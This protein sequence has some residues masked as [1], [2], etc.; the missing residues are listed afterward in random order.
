M[1]MSLNKLQELVME[2]KPGMLQSMG[3]Q[4]AGHNWVM[5]LMI[6]VLQ[7][8]KSKMKSIPMAISTLL[9]FNFILLFLLMMLFFFF[10]CLISV[11][12]RYQNKELGM[13]LKLLDSIF[14]SSLHWPYP[15]ISN[16]SN[17]HTYSSIKYLWNLPPVF[18]FPKNQVI[19]NYSS[20]KVQ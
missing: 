12:S 14:N 9:T 2:G 10:Y 5:K 1:D 8:Q 20:P 13:D 7:I 16:H 18:Y 17:L 11:G 4:R 6:F 19:S 3:S 15:T